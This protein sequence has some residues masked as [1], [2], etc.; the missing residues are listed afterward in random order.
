MRTRG[1]FD[2]GRRRC[3]G[4][5]AAGASMTLGLM[6]AAAHSSVGPVE[7]APAAPD[8]RLIDHERRLSTLPELLRGKVSALQMIF[9]GCS[10]ICP[11]Q[12]AMFSAVQAALS[13][14]RTEGRQL[15]SLSIDP[16][17]DTPQTLQAWR[18]RF[19]AGN[20]WIAVVPAVADLDR[21]QR[22]LTDARGADALDRHS[23]QVFFF[24]AQARLRWRS[25][26]LPS[27]SEVAQVLWQLA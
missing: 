9:T 22:A 19:G 15:V 10:A 6:R 18:M 5:A 12:G 14:A 23:T 13:R 20:N 17:G 27:A 26:E 11:I 3:L 4:M 21:L 8:I 16:L 1:G 7:P 25:P 2:V 24:D